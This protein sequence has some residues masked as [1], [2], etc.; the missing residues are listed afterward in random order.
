M[1]RPR[2]IFGSFEGLK[3]LIKPENKIAQIESRLLKFIKT[4]EWE[5]DEDKKEICRALTQ[6]VVLDF[7][8]TALFKEIDLDVI[9]S[10]LF[11]AARGEEEEERFGE[12]WVENLEEDSL[13]GCLVSALYLLIRIILFFR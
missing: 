3:R 4:E 1:K 6:D 8:R 10:P 5:S 12:E 11:I 2:K 13:N 9:I 7:A